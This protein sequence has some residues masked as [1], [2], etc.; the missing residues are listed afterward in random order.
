[1]RIREKKGRRLNYIQIDRR[2]DKRLAGIAQAFCEVLG[3]TVIADEWLS[4]T[5][6]LEGR[7]L[8]REITV[9][10]D[11]ENRLAAVSYDM[12]FSTEFETGLDETMRFSF[13]KNRFVGGVASD[14][15]E[16]RTALSRLNSEEILDRMRELNLADA[17]IF[18][19]AKTRRCT[20]QLKGL[21]GSSTWMLIPPLM[22]TIRLNVEETR[23]ISE[24]MELMMLSF[25]F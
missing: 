20:I 5:V 7:P 24:L 25:K 6:R 16:C 4:K 21:L 9:H 2:A 12:V 11:V 1:M 3:G 13:R 23:R 14:S 10:Y 15:R 22:E 19:D 18:H 17:A 8:L